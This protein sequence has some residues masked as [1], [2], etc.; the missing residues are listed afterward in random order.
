MA[1]PDFS[2]E[3]LRQIARHG[4]E[5]GQVLA[6]LERFAQGMRWARLDR[7]CRVGDGIRKFNPE[8]LVRL[9][10]RWDVEMEKGRGMKFVPASGA[11]TRMFQTW[12]KALHE[13]AGVD[14]AAVFVEIE[15]YPFYGALR[16][17]MAGAGHSL[18]AGLRHGHYRLILEFLLTPRGLNYAALP[19]GLIPFHSY[20]E[21]SRSPFE[22]HL[23]EAKAYLCDS[24]GHCRLH[25]TVSE[26]HEA[27]V[28]DLF[29]QVLPRHERDGLHFAV[30]LS[31]Q[32]KSTDTIAADSMNRP[33]R[34]REGRLLFRPAGHGALLQ[35]LEAVGGDIVF[36]K[37]IDN[38]AP[39]S[40]KADT[41]LYKKAMAGHLVE[42][43]ETCFHYLR[44]LEAGKMTAAEVAEAEAFASG[45]LS[46]SLPPDWPERS[47]DAR[48]SWL[49]ERLNR[50]L[51]V[52]GMVPNQGDPGGAPFWA[53]ETEG[54]FSLQIVESA[55]VDPSDPDQARIFQSSTHFNPVDLVCGLRDFRGRSFPLSDFVDPEAGF[56]SEKSHQGQVLRAL[57]LPGLWNGGMARWNTVFVEVPAPTFTPVKRVEDLLRP[58]HT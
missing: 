32:K 57:E 35:N 34:D 36:L 16:E 13:E 9:G 58:E 19:K 46:A 37:N 56:L 22:E 5:P 40:K 55:Q 21:G 53:K 27:A 41:I 49:F 45:A 25:F 15:R 2:P 7:P 24:E 31:T 28:R 14:P 17:V 43:Q 54:G 12:L 29:R 50:P 4:M 8:E 33:F 23:V 52:C 20:P 47:G 26:E 44:R 11:G 39:D 1:V 38:V 6:Q 3:D 51:R 18:E 42:I 10:A 48:R 30:E